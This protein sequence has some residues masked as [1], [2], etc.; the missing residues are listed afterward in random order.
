MGWVCFEF[1]L[2]LFVEQTGLLLMFRVCMTDHPCLAIWLVYVAGVLPLPFVCPYVSPILTLQVHQLFPLGRL[3]IWPPMQFPLHLCA[4]I[5][6][7]IFPFVFVAMF[8]NWG[9][10]VS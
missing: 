3:V 9:R 2:C 4:F 10:V 5:A 8:T 7:G 6:A 1:G